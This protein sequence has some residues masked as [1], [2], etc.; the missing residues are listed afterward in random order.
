MDIYCDE[1]INLILLRFPWVDVF[2]EFAQ[3]RL[4]ITRTDLVVTYD[5][6]TVYNFCHDPPLVDLL[7]R[8]EEPMI[9]F[10]EMRPMP[11]KDSVLFAYSKV[12]DRLNEER[13]AS[14]IHEPSFSEQVAE[15][16]DQ[17]LE[18]EVSCGSLGE[19]SSLKRSFNELEDKI[20]DMS[21]GLEKRRKVLEEMIQEFDRN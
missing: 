8:Y 5:Q 20:A 11:E 1:D 3:M 10:E 19:T 18:N 9:D 6:S 13:E 14:L 17:S 16:L 7:S 21:V 15:V 2:R 12:V 4:Q